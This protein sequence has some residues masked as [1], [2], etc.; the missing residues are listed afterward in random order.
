MDINFDNISLDD[1]NDINTIDMSAG[2]HT[3]TNLDVN[4]ILSMTDDNNVLKI[5]GDEGDTVDLGDNF[6]Q[7]DA[8]VEHNPD[9]TTC[10]FYEYHGTGMNDEDMQIL[11]SQDVTVTHGS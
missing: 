10:N 7:G 2:D 1:T 8:V 9:G 4:D 11:I 6:T 3:I 5:F